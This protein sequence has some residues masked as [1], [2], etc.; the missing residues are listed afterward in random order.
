[1]NRLLPVASSC[2]ASRQSTYS[3]AKLASLLQKTDFITAV[4]VGTSVEPRAY[5]NEVPSYAPQPRPKKTNESQKAP[6]D[7]HMILSN[8][9][10][11]KSG[12]VWQETATQRQMSFIN[13]TKTST[14][15]KKDSMFNWK[16]TYSFRNSR[17]LLFN[18]RHISLRWILA[19]NIT[20][21]PMSTV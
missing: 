3:K 1:M 19:P 4:P 21:T 5:S 20:W 14:S 13:P 2:R 6:S 16:Q 7:L 9:G 8:Q 17:S 15:W 10:V 12:V 11:P 18:G